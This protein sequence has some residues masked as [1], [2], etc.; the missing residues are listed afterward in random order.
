[1]VDRVDLAI[2]REARELRRLLPRELD[3]RRDELLLLDERLAL[4]EDRLELK[5]DRVDLVPALEVR[6]RR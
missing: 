2:E 6:R 1:M 5:G 3:D 4:E